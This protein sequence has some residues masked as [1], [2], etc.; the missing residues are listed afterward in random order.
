[1]HKMLAVYKFFIHTHPK[2]RG[3][4]NFAQQPDR[5]STTN[6]EHHFEGEREL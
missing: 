2:E 4:I 5:E 1:M 3:W 6:L